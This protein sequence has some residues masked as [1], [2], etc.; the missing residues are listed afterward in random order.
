[1]VKKDLNKKEKIKEELQEGITI[2]AEEEIVFEDEGVTQNDVTK[3][4]RARLKK[5]EVEKKEFLDGWQRLKAEMVNTKKAQIEQNSKITL[6]AKESVVSELIPVLDSFDMAFTGE[7]WENVD[8]VWRTGIEY[9]HSQFISVL[10]NNGVQNFGVVGDVFD[11]VLHEAAEE[12]SVEDE[13]QDGKLTKVLQVGYKIGDKV[14][15][16]ARVVVGKMSE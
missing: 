15:R 5:C 4:L 6:Y 9:I 13:A 8:Q 1:M 11:P 12:V 14:I 10:E 2:D 16:P 3:K 7:A